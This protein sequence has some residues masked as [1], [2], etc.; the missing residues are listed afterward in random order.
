MQIMNVYSRKQRRRMH[1]IPAAIALLLLGLL[2]LYSSQ[3]SAE[4]VLDVRKLREWQMECRH[5]AVEPRYDIINGEVLHLR[6][7]YGTAALTNGYEASDAVSAEVS[8]GWSLE[9]DNN[10]DAAFTLTVA[11]G[12][13]GSRRIFV[14]HYLWD[15]G[16]EGSDIQD[17]GEDTYTYRLCGKECGPRRWFEQKRDIAADLAEIT[18]ENFAVHPLGFT[19]MLGRPEARKADGSGFFSTLNVVSR[20]APAAAEPV[21]A[22][23]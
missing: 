14:I 15:M 16:A 18:G 1:A 10:Q 5:C 12:E 23:E 11:M 9:Q 21:A 13:T 2:W 19:L 17:L 22:S 7:D 4:T 20:P 3:A 6:T 8:W